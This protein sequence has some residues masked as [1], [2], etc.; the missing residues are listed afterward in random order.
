MIARLPGNFTVEHLLKLNDLYFQ[1]KNRF[2]VNA[3]RYDI[4]F[5]EYNISTLAIELQEQ[6]RRPIYRDFTLQEVAHGDVDKLIS[7]LNLNID[8]NKPINITKLKEKNV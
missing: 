4:P 2:I 8:S 6:P 3:K 5:F 1:T 7:A